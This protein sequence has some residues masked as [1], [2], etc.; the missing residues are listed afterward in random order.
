MET[1]QTKNGSDLRTKWRQA[2][3]DTASY[4]KRL[5]AA[6]NLREEDKITAYSIHKKDIEDLLKKHGKNLDGIRIYIGE[7]QIN[8]ETAIRLHAVAIIK[9]GEMYNDYNVPKLKDL[10]SGRVEEFAT[11]ESTEVSKGFA[12]PHG[13]NQDL[14]GLAELRPCPQEC[15]DKN[16]LNSN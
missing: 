14:Q 10:A 3:S 4:R 13:N 6:K 7:R 1:K 2:F 11:A 9:Q 5:S 16:D 12:N 15:S 8:D